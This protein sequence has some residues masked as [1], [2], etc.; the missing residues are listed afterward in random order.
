M[1]IYI[2]NLSFDVRDADLEGQFSRFGG[3][4]SAKVVNDFDSGQSKGFGFVE[5]SSKQ[6]GEQAIAALNGTE[7]L[8][9][10]ITVNEA[11]PRQPRTGG[12]NGGRTNR[13]GFR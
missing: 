2:G 9:R 6:E 1:N 4:V 5:M 3:V 12:G 8:G 10:A 13:G 11:R 7:L